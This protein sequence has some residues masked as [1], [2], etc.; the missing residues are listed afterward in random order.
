MVAIAVL[1]LGE[2]GARI[3]ADLGACGVAVRGYDPIAVAPPDGVTRTSTLAEAVASVD[4]VLALVPASAVVAVAAD[5]G[6]AL[7]PGT[8][9]ADCAASGVA[10][11]LAAARL[12]GEAGAEFVDL[13]ILGVVPATGLRTPALLSG[14]GATRL[15][16]ILAGLGMPV[17]VVSDRPGDA[18]ERKLLRSVFMKGLAAVVGEALEAGR[19]LGFEDWLLGQ[20]EDELERADGSLV[21]RFEQGTRR[22]APRR[23]VEM[24][25]AVELLQEHDLPAD[26]TRAALARLAR[27]ADTGPDER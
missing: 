11:K 7:A 19:R 22:H 13:A 3:A 1:G 9:Y 16:P 24:A 6:S 18:A 17:E 23:V 4:L 5:A 26:V 27:L 15:A 20:I 14:P 8:I 2:A 12:V 21:S 25:A 10:D